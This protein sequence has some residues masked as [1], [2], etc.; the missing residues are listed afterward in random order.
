MA[1]EKKPSIYDDRSA[2]GSSSELDEYGVWVK[3]EPQDLSGAEGVAEPAA[4]SAEALPGFDLG[5]AGD[6]SFDTELADLP[7]LDLPGDFGEAAD[8]GASFDLDNPLDLDN[9]DA[10]ALE[11]ALPGEAAPEEPFSLDEPL[12][13]GGFDP[14]GGDLEIEEPDLS[15]GGEIPEEENFTEMSLDQFLG[16]PGGEAGEGEPALPSPAVSEEAGEKSDLSTQLLMKI[17]GELSSIRSELS[18]LKEELGSVRQ[19]AAP[20]AEEE[21]AHGFF[22]EEDDEKIALTGDEL[23]NII[24]TAE[25]TEEAGADVTGDLAGEDSVKGA[26]DD[27]SS[28]P[29]QDLDESFPAPLPEGETEEAPGGLDTADLGPADLGPA[30]PGLGDLSLDEPALVDFR[31]ED[32]AGPGGVTHDGADISPADGAE[33]IS[34]PEEEMKPITPAP[35][36]TS[37]LDEDPLAPA[38]PAGGPVPEEPDLD[39]PAGFDTAFGAAEGDSADDV[40]L[41]LSGAVIEEPDLGAALKENPPEE[42]APEDISLEMPLIDLDLEEPDLDL[43]ALDMDGGDEGSPA[44]EDSVEI[45]LDFPEGPAAEEGGS[46]P[47]EGAVL[48]LPGEAEE[49]GEELIPEGFILETDDISPALEGGLEEALPGE[50]LDD[51]DFLEKNPPEEPPPPPPPPVNA[52][53]LPKDI[54]PA[55]TVELR[56]VLSY[57]DHLLESLPEEKIEE[58]AKSEYF[59]TYKKLFKE[60]GIG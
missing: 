38:E 44:G 32:F 10:G 54:S 25:F 3:S 43:P 12:N 49:T 13:L 39:S 16:G 52:G 15:S 24:N 1:S 27:L 57:M 58:F 14:A 28:A 53:E 26:E 17:A 21:P 4:S 11:T 19:G 55:M 45:T 9:F 59:D 41:D 23:D 46:G 2:I 50:D 48:S 5:D 29:F 60:L 20:S 7:T 36:N 33:E 35:E 34:L 31:E 40:S 37:Y 30:D 51:I 56:K 8:A 42:P 6:L 47:E 18:T 22:D